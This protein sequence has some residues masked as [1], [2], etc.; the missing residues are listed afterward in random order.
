MPTE[1]SGSTGVDKIQSDA[2]EKSDLPTG[3]VLQVVTGTPLASNA[4]TTTSGSWVN[5]G[6]SVAI[7]P[8]STNSKILVLQ[9]LFAEATNSNNYTY[10]IYTLQRSIGS[11]AYSIVTPYSS[12]DGGGN[13][14][15][16]LSCRSYGGANELG[17]GISF[18]HLDS[19]NT[20]SECNY[21]VYYRVVAGYGTARI[22]KGSTIMAME[23]AG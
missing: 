2:I 11:G 10:S 8:S 22:Q 15:G 3:S 9:T 19:P 12:V 4:S 14:F 21:L 1:I 20:T 18:N 23:I 6:V 13:T 7:T 16:G 17:A 5:T